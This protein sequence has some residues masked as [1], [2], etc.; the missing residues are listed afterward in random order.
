MGQGWEGVIP[1]PDQVRMRYDVA[2]STPT[3]ARP[4]QGGGCGRGNAIALPAGARGSG[5]L[6]RYL[7]A[8]GL[9]GLPTAPVI[10]NGGAEKKNS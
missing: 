7:I 5:R 4:H 8:A 9:I 3:P 2:N 1:P 10:G 6:V